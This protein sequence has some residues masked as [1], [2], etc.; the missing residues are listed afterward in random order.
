MSGSS[1]KGGMSGIP[2]CGRQPPATAVPTAARTQSVPPPPVP[3]PRRRRGNVV[4]RTSFTFTT[5]RRRENVAAPSAPPLLPGEE[6]AGVRS[7]GLTPT[8]RAAAY[9]V[10]ARYG[11]LCWL[12]EGCM[13]RMM[14]RC[15]TRCA[16]HHGPGI[17]LDRWRH[18]GD[19]A[20]HALE[21]VFGLA[22]GG[23]PRMVS[24]RSLRGRRAR[25]G[26]PSAAGRR[27]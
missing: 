6:R 8:R 18:R 16:P 4:E 1:G 23:V 9:L 25:A 21:Q 26:A 12:D 17:V 20:G 22:P 15:I 19:I 27:S 24:S 11:P 14:A 7:L 13:A 10:S 2:R 3:L 5:S